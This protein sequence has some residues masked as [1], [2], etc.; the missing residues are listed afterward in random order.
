MHSGY[1]TIAG[2]DSEKDKARV[3]LARKATDRG[4]GE[5]TVAALG[6]GFPF[7]ASKGSW[8]SKKRRKRGIC[9]KTGEEKVDGL[10]SIR[11]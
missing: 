2:R 8:D 1:C 11:S 7:K 10:N 6:A 4:K 5:K 9:Q 3:G